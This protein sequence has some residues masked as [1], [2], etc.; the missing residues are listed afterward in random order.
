MKNRLFIRADGSSDIGLGHLIRCL[1]LAHMLKYDFDVSF[2]CKEIPASTVADI[3]NEGFGFQAILEEDDFFNLLYGNEIIVVDHYELDARYHTKLKEKGCMVV[4]IDDIHDKLF[5]ADL[6]INHAPGIK[7]ED[8][9]VMSVTQFAF[10]L[11]YALLRPAF[12]AEKRR[13]KQIFDVRNLLICFGGS[14]FK[15]LTLRSLKIALEFGEI[16]A[17]TII[18]G[19]SYL[20]LDHLEAEVS[21]NT[22]ISH[23]H[24]VGESEMADLIEK[25]NVAIV[26]SSGILL[27][28]IALGNQLISGMYV[29]NQKVLFNEYKKMGAFVSAEDFSDPYLRK[30]IAESLNIKKKPLSLIDGKSGDRIRKLFKQLLNDRLLFLRKA[31]IQDVELTY[32]W[33]IDKRIRAFSFSTSEIEFFGHSNWFLSKIND[34]NC[35]YYIAE[36][37][38][39]VVGSIRFDVSGEQAIIS[40]LVDAEFHNKGYGVTLLKKGIL[41]I[42]NNGDKRIKE[43][44]GYVLIEN[45]ASSKAFNKLGFSEKLEGDRYKYT[46]IIDYAN[47]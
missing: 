45:I 42:A 40:Y 36:L 35:Y 3:K 1:S 44:V 34:E 38:D 41:A 8:Y 28:A 23:Y 22:S 37:K 6:I 18:T 31:K 11:D 21:N 12:L 15:N 26:P 43:I 5:N 19:N 39:T 47:W 24:A 4:C 25:A 9:Q 30:A 10:G 7:S 46:K 13:T 17:I 2:V 20:Y 33:A 29:D 27:E 16:N 14:D 32:K